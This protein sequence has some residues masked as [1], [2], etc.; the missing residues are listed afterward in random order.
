[1]RIQA[2]ESA[3]SGVPRTYESGHNG[4]RPRPSLPVRWSD[5]VRFSMLLVG[6]VVI[7][8]AVTWRPS[9]SAQ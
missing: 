7:L 4:Q 5:P 8:G 1:M 9:A 2:R 6:L 3:L